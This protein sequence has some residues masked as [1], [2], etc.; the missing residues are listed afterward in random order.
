MGIVKATPRVL[1]C[2]ASAGLRHGLSRMKGNF[3]VRFEG[4]RRRQRR[5]LTRRS[6]TQP[7][8]GASRWSFCAHLVEQRLR[9][10][11]KVRAMLCG[12]QRVADTWTV[13]GLS[14]IVCVA[15]TWTVRNRS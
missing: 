14:V 5:L 8:R 12:G 9:G 11:G 2:S 6:V 1:T 7:H 4:R 13:R 15:H 3:H 10:N